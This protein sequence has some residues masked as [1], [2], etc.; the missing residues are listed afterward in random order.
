MV[1]VK[2]K[3]PEILLDGVDS[4]G[5][6]VKFSLYEQLEKNNVKGAVLFF[7][8]LDFTFVCPTELIKLNESFD[9]F[10]ERGILLVGISIDSKFSHKAWREKSIKDGGIGELDY[11]LLSD[12]NKTTSRN[13]EILIENEQYFNEDVDMSEVTREVDEIALRATFFIDSEGTVRHQSINDLPIG[14]NIDEIL[15]I[16]DAWKYHEKH[17][18]VCPAGW[19]KGDSGM[20]AN[21]SGLKD[22]MSSHIKE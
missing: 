20:E 4:H 11:T 7:Y 17:G 18:E 14:R 15:R 5:S 10:Q 6:F 22:Y 16:I 9:A 13:Y 2:K 12:I 21:D 8:P 1:L 3:A 19:S